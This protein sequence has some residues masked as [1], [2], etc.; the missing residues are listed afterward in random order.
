MP[1]I[2]MGAYGQCSPPTTDLCPIDGA[3]GFPSEAVFNDMAL[4]ED[5][6]TL[7]VSN[8]DDVPTVFNEDGAFD[9]VKQCA[10][11]A[12]WSAPARTLRHVHHHCPLRDR[13]TPTISS[14][15][16]PWRLH[17]RLQ[18]PPVGADV[19]HPGPGSNQPSIT[20]LDLHLCDASGPAR[21]GQKHAGHL[22]KVSQLRALCQV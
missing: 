22:W 10:A 1:A 15:I 13:I 14:S 17:Y 2:L 18:A 20:G 6:D 8:G 7:N 21:V 4:E 19:K 3:V 9:A 5:G 11:Q 12:W 16:A